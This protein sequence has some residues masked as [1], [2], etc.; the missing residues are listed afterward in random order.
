MLAQWQAGS[1]LVGMIMGQEGA[2]VLKIHIGVS[3]SLAGTL[4]TTL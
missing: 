4:F 3:P 2:S 1:L